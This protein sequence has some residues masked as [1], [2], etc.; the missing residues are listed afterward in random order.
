MNILNDVL[1][2]IDMEKWYFSQCPALRGAPH[3]NRADRILPSYEFS[4]LAFIP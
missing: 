4:A 3:A 1:G 2:V